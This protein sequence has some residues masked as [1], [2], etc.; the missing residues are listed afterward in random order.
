MIL[1]RVR[2]DVV[3]PIKNPHL[4]GR[5]LLLCQPVGLDEKPRGQAIVAVDLVE[6]GEG[7]LVLVN[8]EG[9]GAR[10]ALRDEATPVQSIVVAVV[11]GIHLDRRA[12]AENPP[13]RRI[14]GEPR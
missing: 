11:E 14:P 13:V 1:C 4:E 5:K 6:A 2:G 3:A 7:D 10:I 8:K 9:G 12:P